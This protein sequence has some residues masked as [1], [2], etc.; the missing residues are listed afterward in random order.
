MSAACV[1]SALSVLATASFQRSCSAACYM[2]TQDGFEF[3][4]AIRSRW[5]ATAVILRSTFPAPETAKQ[6]LEAGA[7]AFLSKPF[8]SVITE[9]NE[10][11][12]AKLGRRLEHLSG[13]SLIVFVAASER[14][15]FDRLLSSM[16][17]G[18]ARR[19][20]PRELRFE[21]EITAGLSALR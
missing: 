7:L 4:A 12:E 9:E 19:P 21:P 2:P 13:K 11:A 14:A 18:C 17:E 10:A 1:E 3:V 5:P 20:G 6:A 8:S 16:P 15:D